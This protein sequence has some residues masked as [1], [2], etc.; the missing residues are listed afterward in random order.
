MLPVRCV[1]RTWQLGVPGQTL[2]AG[3]VRSDTK[4]LP[5]MHL[6]S[7]SQLQAL[8]RL[9]VRLTECCCGSWWFRRFQTLNPNPINSK[10][11]VHTLRCRATMRTTRRTASWTRSSTTPRQTSRALSGSRRAA[12]TGD[13]SRCFPLSLS[14]LLHP[15][16]CCCSVVPRQVEDFGSSQEGGMVRLVALPSYL[17]RSFSPGGSAARHRQHGP[18][19][20]ASCLVPPSTHSQHAPC[21][22][23]TAVTSPGAGPVGG[24]GVG[25][26]EDAVPMGVGFCV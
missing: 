14:Y 20:G 10:L 25:H 17:W 19:Q 1:R 21:S 13:A 6:A 22:F 24:A 4:P 16:P 2:D 15:K 12:A 5:R 23:H 9:D 7:D 26:G 11:K 3:L 8:G 18:P